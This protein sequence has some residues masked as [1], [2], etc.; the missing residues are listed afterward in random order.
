ME[1]EKFYLL[2]KKLLIKREKKVVILILVDIYKVSILSTFVAV[3]AA[4]LIK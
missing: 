3:A 2:Y 4:V 1:Y